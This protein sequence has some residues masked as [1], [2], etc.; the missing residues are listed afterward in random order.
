MSW[1][2]K[3]SISLQP[4]PY[5]LDCERRAALKMV[6]H[7]RPD[8]PLGFAQVLEHA[9]QGGDFAVTGIDDL[10]PVLASPLVHCLPVTPRKGARCPTGLIFPDSRV[11]PGQ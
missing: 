7:E 9:R 11:P 1:A 8:L 4:L 3:F 2:Q 6:I 10:R 5:P